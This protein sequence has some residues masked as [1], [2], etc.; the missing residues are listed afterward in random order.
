M[1]S[2]NPTPPDAWM[3]ACVEAY[4]D[5]DLSPDERARF[6]RRLRASPAWQARVEQARTIQQS[7]RALPQPPCPPRVAGAVRAEVRRRQQ[8]ALWPER[9]ARPP[10]RRRNRTAW[11]SAVVAGLLLALTFS[12][13]WLG[14]TSAPESAPYTE[15]EVE[16]AAAEVTWTLA[17][18]ARIG[19]ETG[20]AIEEALPDSRLIRSTRQALEP[21]LGGRPPDDVS[22]RPSKKGGG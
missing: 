3:D 2:P 14:R 17:Y 18:L 8:R 22:N 15:A 9:E 12:A 13:L 16:R 6:E 21:V 1:N 11:T 20:Q 4:V 7:L 5:G 19:E 10:V